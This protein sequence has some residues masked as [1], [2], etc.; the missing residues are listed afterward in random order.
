M[1]FKQSILGLSTAA[2]MALGASSQ[3][4]A[5]AAKEDYVR[6]PMPAGF[7]VVVTEMDGPVF[8][9]AQGQTVYTWPRR[10][11][12]NGDAGEVEGKP[13][14]TDEVARE[15][16]GFLSP[17]PAGLEMP[18]LD[19]RPACTGAWPPVLA[20]ADAK[21]AGK[22][23][24]VNRPD[25]RKQWAYDGMA[26]YTSFLDKRPGDVLGGSNMAGVGEGGAARY[27]VGPESN[28]PAQ[29]NVLTTMGGRLVTLRDGWSIY[30]YD[31]D[32]RRKSNCRDACLNDW[33][34]ILAAASSG[35]VGD[36][37]TFERAPGVKQWAFRGQP[38]YRRMTDP[39]V[40]SLD[41]AET[42]G[43]RNVYVQ[44]AP[45][46]PP[47]FALK[48]TLVGMTLGDSK[49]MTIYRYVCSDD[50]LDQLA[51][52][53]PAA[54]QLYRMAV[55]GGGD[56]DICA[57]AFPYVIAAKGAKSGSRIWGTMYIDPKTGK[58]AAADAPGAL[59]VWTFRER[60]VYTFAGYKGYGDKKP[61]DIN[62]HA[63]GEVNGGRNG[64]AALVYR[65]IF[66]DRD[67]GRRS[68]R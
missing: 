33:S 52:D 21:D 10:K 46:P 42:P 62:A 11:L 39:K 49:G 29:F 53:Y 19:T 15:N 37:T 45:T 16:T 22:F 38:V 8:A 17:Y 56:P 59:H 36:W 24:V 14:C 51:C 41:G 25:G 50:A 23:T 44:D 6:E 34:P 47:G 43:W 9:T 63:W 2:F 60:P 65:D 35:P 40:G 54:P 20:S 31:G 27:P 58:E 30:T 1:R 61:T 48:P 57:K 66:E 4:S 26:L 18:E 55:C 5:A 28:V 68:R 3:A 13:T 64:Y 67:S 7:Q 12:R 32:A